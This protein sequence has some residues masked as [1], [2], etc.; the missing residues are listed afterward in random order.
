LEA[1]ACGKPVIASR[2][3]FNDDI[4][5]DDYSYRID[6]TSIDEISKSIEYCYYNR[7]ELSIKGL[8]ALKF[9]KINTIDRRVEKILDFIEL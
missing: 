6:V 2:E 8:N 5:S 3:K 4:L 1:L 7:D 9:S